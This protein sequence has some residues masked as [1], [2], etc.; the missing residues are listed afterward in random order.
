M[1]SQT[2]VP[3]YTPF[4]KGHNNIEIETLDLPTIITTITT[5]LN[6]S[7]I[8]FIFMDNLYEWKLALIDNT[9]DTIFNVSVTIYRTTICEKYIVNVSNMTSGNG[10]RETKTLFNELKIRF[11]Q[12]PDHQQLLF[13][14]T[15]PNN[16]NID[17][18][19]DTTEV[20]NT[21]KQMINL[22]RVGD[23]EAA[24]SVIKDLTKNPQTI[25]ILFASEVF[26]NIITLIR[27]ILNGVNCLNTKYKAVKTLG[28]MCDHKTTIMKPYIEKIIP[29]N[30]TEPA[31]YRETYLYREYLRILQ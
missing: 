23:E 21:I 8:P 12:P 28:A 18:E 7:N 5:Y 24:I 1:F 30:I 13:G 11:G 2:A 31:N 20:I 14:L 9:T 29:L 10:F 17:F 25:E 26:E 6:S 27:I 19:L 22:S 3:Q 15:M 16:N 4:Y